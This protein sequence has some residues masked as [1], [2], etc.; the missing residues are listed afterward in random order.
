MAD[1]KISTLDDAALPL[2]GNELLE[3]SQ[4]IGEAYGSVKGTSANVSFAGTKYGSFYDLT[5]Q[6][7]SVSAATAVKLS[8]TDLSR[9]VTVVTNGSA[10]TRVTFSEGGVYMVAPS[11]QFVNS[12][13]NDHDA[14]I[15]FSKN[16][17]ALAASASRMTIPKAAD[18]GA[19]LFQIVYYVSVAGGDYVEVMWLPENAA[20]T[21]DTT[22]AGAIAP[23][24]P[25]V[26]LVTERISL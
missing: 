8:G 25:S 26:L 5:D 6:T 24:V 16:G 14:T 23:A 10:L 22:A 9:G 11:I 1:Q 2:S 20:V 19:A 7:G 3:M 4:L 15:W 17:T 12:D 13:T 18:G 21:I